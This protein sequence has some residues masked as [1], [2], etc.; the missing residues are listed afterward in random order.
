MK[1]TALYTSLMLATFLHGQEIQ[2]IKYVNLSRISQ[3]I[4]DETIDLRVGDNI[5]NKSINSAIKKFYK[6]GYFDDIKVN[7]NNGNIEFIFKE[8]PSIA[9][10]EMNN[11]KSRDE[12]KEE[13]Y[14]RMGI[15]KGNMYTPSKIKHAK[16]IL[17]KNLER[18]GY[19]NSVVEVNVENLD[20]DAVAVTF[21]VNVGDEI[22]IKK[23]N[24]Y[25]ATKL[26][27]DDFTEVTA[28]NQRDFIPWWFGNNNGEV[29]LEQLDYDAP[30]I[31]DQYLKNGYLDSVVKDPFM[32]IN[33]ASN[34]A[35]LDFFIQEG[36]QYS[37]NDIK[38][39]VDA[40]IIDPKTLY[41]E[42]K[43]EKGDVFN[44]EKLRKD[45]EYLKTKVSD[46]GY[47]FTQVKYDI[48]KNEKNG[49][50][51]VVFNIIPGKKVYINDVIISGNSR[52]LDRVIRRDVYLAPGDLFSLTDFNESKDK[53]KR[54]GFFDDV[55]IEQKRVTDNSMDLVVKV[56]ETPTG[57]ITLGGGYGSYDGLLL[58]AGINEKNV[59]GSGLAAAVNVDFSE[60]NHNYALSLSNPAIR[61]SKYNGR[62]EIH[63]SEEEIDYSGTVNGA[64]QLDKV[65]KGF[66]ISAGREIIRN[67][68]AGARYRFDMIDESYTDTDTSDGQPLPSDVNQDYITSSITPYI[69]FDNTDDYMIPRRGIKT[70][71]SLEFAGVGGDSKY[72]KSLTN[73]R[74]FHSLED[75]IDSD[76][77]FRYRANLNFLVDN[78]QLNRG[79]SLYMGG[80]K[81]LRGYE[82]YAFGPDDNLVNKTVY[83]QMFANSIEL[84]FP[85]IPKSKMRWG[86]F[87]D[88]GM[89]GKDSFSEVKRSGTG[90]LFEW[91]SP[92]GPLQFIFSQPLDDKQGDKTSTFEFALGSS[93]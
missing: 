62:V 57:N 42:L 11:Y 53:L 46:L 75:L 31:R 83:K 25:G 34:D 35:V 72:L 45:V 39:Y 30:R 74:Y 61:D 47:A 90:A 79:D 1:K 67:L 63:Q 76:W 16:E 54:T 36:K 7:N 64:Y 93:F 73:F 68:Y 82:S 92:F 52:T 40:S 20:N 91:I 13:L 65:S 26:E 87:Y 66:S 81:S 38:I 5:N 86:V 55:I 2:S 77:I 71:T 10:I 41:S 21:D 28:N 50:A 8:K 6:F 29:N 44:I 56:K 69:N 60:K 14:S 59:F 9:N 89:I 48:N 12:D 33:F 19:V 23:V 88:Y 24:Y 17:L 58:N 32:K 49:T 85:L 27:A 51:D 78:G 15:K 84:S 3:D 80:P 37:T 43:L 70:G 18:E 22:L 4:A